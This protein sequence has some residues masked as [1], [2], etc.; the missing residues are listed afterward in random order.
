VRV[1][2]GAFDVVGVGGGCQLVLTGGEEGG[3]SGGLRH[4]VHRAG[5]AEL[6]HHAGTVVADDAEVAQIHQQ[7]GVV[8]EPEERLG[9]GTDQL[10]V[11]VREDGDLVIASDAGDDRLDLG[12]GEGC[13][14]VGGPVLGTRA[15]PTGGR[16]LHRLQSEGLLQPANAEVVGE[17]QHLGE[18]SGRRQDGDAVTGAGLGRV[19][20]LCHAAIVVSPVH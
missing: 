1:L 19:G 18:T 6:R 2:P 8:A 12:V 5:S 20:R 13:V 7:V 11:Q 10:A 3:A 15:E 16:I 4:R 9:V 14:Q 17:W